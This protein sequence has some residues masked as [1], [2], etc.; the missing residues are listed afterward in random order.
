MSPTSRRSKKPSSRKSTTSPP[1][2]AKYSPTDSG[3]VDVAAGEHHAD[4]AP[5]E[6]VGVF[7]NCG[8]TRGPCAFR[9]HLL[10]LEE[11]VDTFLDR[12]LAHGEH[13]DPRIREQRRRQRP[14]M[15]D[16]DAFSHR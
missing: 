15:G 1:K 7:D 16:G 10:Y 14:G 2:P 11:Q 3:R 6:S 12:P 13:I 9:D 8:Q 5:G 4:R